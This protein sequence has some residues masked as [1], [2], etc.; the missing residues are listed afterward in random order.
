VTSIKGLRV[1]APSD[2]IHITRS[3]W[4]RSPWDHTHRGRSLH[5]HCRQT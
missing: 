5:V 3:I 2:T 4:T 1:S